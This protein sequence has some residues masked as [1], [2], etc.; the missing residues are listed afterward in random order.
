VDATG[1]VACEGS[2]RSF[3]LEVSAGA[4]EALGAATLFVTVGG[5]RRD[6]PMAVT[7]ATADVL[8]GPLPPTSTAWWVG[9]SGADGGSAGTA[10]TPLNHPCG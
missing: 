5:A 2:S 6:Y 10:A 8:S 1:R 7:G 4:S 3:R 9:V